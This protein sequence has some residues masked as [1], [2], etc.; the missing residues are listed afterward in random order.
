MFNFKAEHIRD[1]GERTISTFV[2]ASI[3]AMGTNSVMD[4]GVENWKMVVAAGVSAAV[5][6]VKGWIAKN[7]GNPDNASMLKK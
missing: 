3:G 4:L 2:Q 6:V 7:I 5:A 1:L